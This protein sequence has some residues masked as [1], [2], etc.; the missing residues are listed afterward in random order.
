MRFIFI[1]LAAFAV[2]AVQA[3]D[4][5]GRV[6]NAD[7]KP[8]IGANV[9]LYGTAFGTFTDN[10]GN[11]IIEQVPEGNYTIIVAMMGYLPYKSLLEISKA[12]E[13]R[14]GEVQLIPSPV[15]G[16]MVVVTASKYEQDIQN[17]PASIS[18]VDRKEITSRNATTIDKALQYVPGINLNSAQV[19]IRGSSGYSRGVGSRVLFLL[20][21]IPFLTGDTREIS[22]DVIPS[23]MVNRIEVVKGAGSALYGSSALGG[24]VN[25]ITNDIQKSPPYYAKIYGGL[26]SETAY[27]E[28]N[29][30]KDA[31]YFQG[32][33]FGITKKV[34]HVGLQLGGSY[35]GDDSYRENDLRERYTGSGKI[36]FLISPR[37]NLSFTGNYMYQKRRNFLFWRNLRNALRPPYDQIDD[38][39]QSNRYFLTTNYQHILG[40]KSYFT[41]RGIWFWNRFKDTVSAGGGNQSTSRNLTG[42]LQFNTKIQS[43]LITVGTEFT[44]NTVESNIFGIHSGS[45][46]A[47]YLQAEF[48]PTAKWNITLGARLDFFDIDS[49]ESELQINPKIGIV[50]RPL[51]GTAL[52]SSFGLGFRA[53][54]MAEIFTSTDA[55]GFLVV[56]NLTLKPERS[57]YFEIGWNQFFAKRLMTDIT[58]F[59]SRYKDLI[60]G[61]FLESGEVQFQNITRA[62]VQGSE[63]H[64]RAQLIP[65]KMNLLL[66]HTYV[67]PID[68]DSKEYL[69]FRPRHLF[70]ANAEITLLPFNFG[71]DYRYIKKYD[72][73]DE[74][75]SLII[76]DAEQ[77]VDAHV[78]DMRLSYDLNFSRLPV[79]IS[80]ILNNVFRYYYVD[81]IGSLAPLRQA[82]ISLETIF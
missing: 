50:Y 22:F 11:F 76:Q 32:V 15:S 14:L 17:V 69:R 12:G 9:Y 79:K 18:L 64:L 19:N 20:D 65:Q 39:V 28:W 72:R 26:F 40:S 13:H 56:P 43:I 49:V 80:F 6:I 55:S 67:D 82:T 33:S 78:V 54:S 2:S 58:Y 8:L 16:E 75:F 44:R 35:D 23:Y 66:G 24:V 7:N 41:I 52:R 51:E 10:Q 4:I 46:A 81:L 31:R 53:P 45:G 68:L 73:I 42:E 30:S 27:K 61:E 1:I 48:S 70:H 60:E 59:Y 62:Q 36:Q 71:L 63:I 57:R 37:Q 74:K 29:W 77:R 38:E 34:N 3:A 25:I 21:G 47:T 5:S